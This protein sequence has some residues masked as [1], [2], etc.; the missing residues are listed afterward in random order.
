MGTASPE[1]SEVG[2][3]AEVGSVHLDALAVDLDNG[4][5]GRHVLRAG[6]RWQRHIRPG[7]CCHSYQPSLRPASSLH[8][9]PSCPSL[10]APQVKSWACGEGCL[11]SSSSPL[12]T[13]FSLYSGYSSTSKSCFC[14]AKPNSRRLEKTSVSSIWSRLER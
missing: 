13:E 2:V 1:P 8:R 4:S 6:G 12:L 10:E 3:D 14:S 9:G 5:G 7:P 11:L